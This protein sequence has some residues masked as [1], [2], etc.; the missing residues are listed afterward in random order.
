MG[1][2]TRIGTVVSVN[3]GVPRPVEWAG[4]EVVT[5]IWKTPTT[6]R[7]AVAGVN[8]AG[9]AQADRR[10]HGGPDKAVY[11]YALEDYEWWTGEVGAPIAPATFGENLTVS[12]IDL[13]RAVVGEVWSVGSTRLQI[14]QPRMP[15]FKLGIRMGDAGFVERFEQARRHGAYLRIVDEGDVGAG[16]DI[17]LVSRPSHGL[18]VASIAEIFESHEP[19]ELRRLADIDDV[20]VSWREWA[21]R[22]LERSARRT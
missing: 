12:G 13:G 17:D 8:L 21:E 6:G 19:R 15:C 10:V 14:A 20:P 9:D 7:V 22:Q 4:R 18:T 11:A 3:V 16:D 5:S 2:V 1:D